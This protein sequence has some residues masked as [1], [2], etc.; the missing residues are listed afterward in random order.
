MFGRHPHL[1]VDLLLGADVSGS[2]PQS[3]NKYV[4][5][6]RRTFEE[7]YKLVLQKSSEKKSHQKKHYHKKLRGAMVQVGDRVLIRNVGFQGPHKL[8]DRWQEPVYVVQNQPDSSVPVFEVR[9]EDGHGDVQTLHW[10]MLLPICAIGDVPQ[11]SAEDLIVKHLRMRNNPHQKIPLHWCYLVNHPYHYLAEGPQ[12]HTLYPLTQPEW[13]L[14][15]GHNQSGTQL[16]F[17]N[18]RR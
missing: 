15:C 13:N 11:S 7:S 3:Y 10:N 4:D 14:S 5:D 18:I 6:L 9:R 1:P 12:F 17:R 2:Q 8:A 16:A